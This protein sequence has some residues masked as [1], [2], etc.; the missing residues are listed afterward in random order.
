MIAG[1][2]ALL[3]ELAAPSRRRQRPRHRQ[4]LPPGAT[5]QSSCFATCGWRRENGIDLL[6]RLTALTAARISGIL[7]SGDTSPETQAA[8]TQAGYALLHKPVSPAKLRAVVMNFAWKL[9]ETNTG[10]LRDEDSAR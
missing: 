9:R 3:E 8:A 10:E 2:R 7:I 6:R 5:S 4:R 1:N